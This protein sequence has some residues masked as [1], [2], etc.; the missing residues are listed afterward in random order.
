[1]Q[2]RI[3]HIELMNRSGAGDSQGEDGAD[4]G[5][6]D[7][8]AEG[9][10]VVDTRSLG[11]AVKN[12]ASLVPFQGAV[13]IELVLKNPLAS[14]DV[15]ANGARDKIPSVVDDQGSK[16]FFHGA[17]NLDRRGRHGWRRAPVTRST[18]KWPIG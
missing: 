7:H 17:A 2:E 11:E 1:V 14:D 8:R 12:L 13:E 10:I 9:L 15:G 18:P 16:F 5:R 3:L 6:L 4:R